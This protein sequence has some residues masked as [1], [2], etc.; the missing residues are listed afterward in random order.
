MYQENNDL[1]SPYKGN[2]P[3]IFISYSHKNSGEVL[4]IISKLRQLEFRIWYDSGI[5][6]GS[7]WDENIASHISGCTYFIAFISN[8]YLASSN[9]RDELNF[10]RDKDKPLLLVY[11]E[12]TKLP[13]GMSM[14]LNRLQ[15]IHK[16]AC[17]R[18]LDF[19]QKI[20]EADGI[21]VCRVFSNGQHT[22]ASSGNHSAPQTSSASAET[23]HASLREKAGKRKAAASLIC[24]IL[25][26][27]TLILALC[28]CTGLDLIGIILSIAAIIL[29][30]SAKKK[31]GI[32]NK[33]AKAGKIT[34]I[35][36]L[37]IEG[38]V[39]V[40]GLITGIVTSLI[41]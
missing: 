37:S 40:I 18:E 30:S 34:A 3:Y 8:E 12:D 25:S 20:I 23:D 41:V 13:E 17:A 39:A 19:Y 28:G 24:G 31:N 15:A 11:L 32:V 9:C 16:Y 2:Q 14:R 27:M 29:S 36:F 26:L 22:N 5:D 21:N 35:V 10:A 6:P 4:N 7:E 38:F 1:F 33:K